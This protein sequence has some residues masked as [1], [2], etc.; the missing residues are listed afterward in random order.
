MA[1]GRR[2]PYRPGHY[3]APKT[4]ADATKPTHAKRDTYDWATLGIAFVGVVIVA[5]STAIAAYQAIVTRQELDNAISQ[6][7]AWVRIDAIPTSDVTVDSIGAHFLIRMT[8]TNSGNLPAVGVWTDV[9]TELIDTLPKSFDE[10]PHPERG[11]LCGGGTY[12]E[13]GRTVFPGES[14]T[15]QVAVLI[16][17]AE[18]ARF[19]KDPFKIGARFC[20]V[21]YDRSDR[22]RHTD[23]TITISKRWEVERPYIG[24][25]KAGGQFP[26]R[27][28]T[29]Q[30]EASGNQAD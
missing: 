26:L 2:G 24:F 8:L 22:V 3:Q 14:I 23:R 4:P 5:A 11:V 6:Q 16:P 17:R 29:T 20:A 15:E 25:A 9:T 19:P 18:I 10:A 13:V 21:Y 28:L 1:K 12:P 27:Q 7:R 30:A